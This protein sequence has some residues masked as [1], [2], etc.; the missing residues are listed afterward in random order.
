MDDLIFQ[1]LNGDDC[2][3]ISGGNDFRCESCCYK[4]EC[5]NLANQRCN[6]EFAENINYGGYDTEEEFWE[7]LFD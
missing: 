3:R 6:S 4:E 7:Q 5:Y 1:Y 2:E